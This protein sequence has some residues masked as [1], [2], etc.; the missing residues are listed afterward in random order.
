MKALRRKKWPAAIALTAM[1]G[2]IASPL[3]YAGPKNQNDNSTITPIKHLI[4][5]IGENRTFDNTFATYQPKHGQTVS[6]LLSRAIVDA[7]GSPGL[8]AALATQN[9]VNTPLPPTYFMSSTNKT[10]YSPLPTPELGGAPN[11]QHPLTAAL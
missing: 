2:Q 1:L 7:N 9:F 3:A 4:V 6:N 5:L 10:A 8:N 11:V